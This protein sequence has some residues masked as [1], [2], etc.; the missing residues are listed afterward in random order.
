MIYS[1][2]K[3]VN[4]LFL[5]AIL[6]SGSALSA[7]ATEGLEKTEEQL[8]KERDVKKAFKKAEIDKKRARSK[9]KNEA[10][11]ARQKELNRSKDQE[12]FS[13]VGLNKKQIEKYNKL[14]ET[15][16]EKTKEAMQKGKSDPATMG[17]EIQ[18]I[19][20]KR[21]SEMKKIFKAGQFDK[22]MEFNEM[23]ASKNRKS[24]HNNVVKKID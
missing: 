24:K 19:R 16:R 9:K 20:D 3:S 22:Y 5:L 15:T 17:Q 7:Q 11:L 2:L 1:K 13:Y 12:M 23:K 8:Q 6:C 14:T 21:S 10:Y 18:K 4:L